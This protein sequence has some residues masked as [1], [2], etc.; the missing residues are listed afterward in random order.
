MAKV[1]FIFKDNSVFE[2]GLGTLYF[3][4]QHKML[5]YSNDLPRSIS[6]DTICSL[7]LSS[8]EISFESEDDNHVS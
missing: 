5:I 2:T 3:S 1:K 4:N 8:I 6:S 7:K